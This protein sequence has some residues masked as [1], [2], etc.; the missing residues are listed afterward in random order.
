MFN[1][2]KKHY[3]AI[4]LSLIVGGLTALPQ[5]L[6]IQKV[7]NFQG[8][9]KS[10]NN[11]EP[12]YMARAKD[13][14]D[15]HSMLANPF[16]YEY[17]DSYPMQF[18]LPDYI[19][20]K[21]LAILNIDLHLGYLFYDFLLPFVLTILTYSIAFRLTGSRTFGFLGAVFLHLTNH[22]YIFN[23][24]PSPQ[25]NFIFWLL[26]FLCWLKFLEKPN[27]KNIAMTGLSFGML[28]HIYTYYWTFYATFF[29][30][31]IF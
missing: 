9:Y 16:I 25:L 5:I 22:I 14:I 24:A 20:A 6:A 4:I 15:G 13:V 3:I 28:F 8:L 31:F 11:D 12:Y 30:I 7:D 17:K 18:W 23:R 29:A 21:P 19:L 26:L 10:I 27:F 2:I 1:I